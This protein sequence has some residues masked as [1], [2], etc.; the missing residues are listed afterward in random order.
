MMNQGLF[1]RNQMTV[2]LPYWA[3]QVKRAPTEEGGSTVNVAR[4]I[5]Y[6]FANWHA[7]NVADSIVKE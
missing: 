1:G 3:I 7:R 5:I 2:G 6:S 4:L